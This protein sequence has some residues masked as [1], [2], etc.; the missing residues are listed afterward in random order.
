MR[1]DCVISIIITINV[2]NKVLLS[3]L[4]LLPRLSSPNI[5]KYRTVPRRRKNRVRRGQIRKEGRGKRGQRKVEEEGRR[6]KSE[7]GKDAGN[8]E[9][10]R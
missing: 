9:G 3:A 8:K 4:F 5:Y 1:L 10:E 2:N 7:D 6:K